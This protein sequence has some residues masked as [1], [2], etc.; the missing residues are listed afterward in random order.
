MI[1]HFYVVQSFTVWDI[2]TEVV[3]ILL[4]LGNLETFSGILATISIA[5]AMSDLPEES[6]KY[7]K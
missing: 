5:L 7:E 4:S 3:K 2:L 6:D 1:L